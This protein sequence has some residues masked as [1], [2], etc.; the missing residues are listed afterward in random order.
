MPSVENHA[1][2]HRMAA[3]RRGTHRCSRDACKHAGVAK[4]PVHLL[5]LWSTTIK[6]FSIPR[7]PSLSPR[8][9]RRAGGI[10]LPAPGRR[11]QFHPSQQAGRSDHRYRWL[12]AQPE[13]PPYCRRRH[14][15]SRQPG[16]PADGAG[17][18]GRAVGGG[19]H[20]PTAT[21]RA[22]APAAALQLHVCCR[23]LCARRLPSTPHAGHLPWRPL[24]GRRLPR[25][26]GPRRWRNGQRRPS[27]TAGLAGGSCLPSA[28]APWRQ[29]EEEGS[30]RLSAKRPPQGLPPAAAAPQRQPLA[31]HAA[32]PAHS[33]APPSPPP[34]P[35]PPVLHATA[36]TA[37][38]PRPQRPRRPFPVRVRPDQTTALGRDEAG[39]EGKMPP[40][41]EP[42]LPPRP[43]PCT[44][45]ART[46]SVAA[47]GGLGDATT[48]V[49]ATAASATAMAAA[50]VCVWQQLEGHHSGRRRRRRPGGC[51]WRQPPGSYHLRHRRRRQRLVFS[52][53]EYRWGVSMRARA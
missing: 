20:P 3:T 47:W 22:V 23:L 15:Y 26:A 14:Y 45:P 16:E 7:L 33:P 19:E 44:S 18:A 40:A 37:S 51:H 17:A 27:M 25:V 1:L 9:H 52:R 6:A 8:W 13:G 38:V 30:P 35:M 29:P 21:T 43:C 34:P 24:W 46:P 39:Q 53:R 31:Q 50:A 10:A 5:P 28:A 36:A 41:P 32:P 12:P 42:E 11:H 4:V 48:M 49:S 2:V